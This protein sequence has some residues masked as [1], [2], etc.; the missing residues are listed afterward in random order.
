MVGQEFYP[1]EFEAYYRKVLIKRKLM[2]EYLKFDKQDFYA[3]KRMVFEAWKKQRKA[4][5]VQ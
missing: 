2:F 4:G 1:S 3:H 5:V